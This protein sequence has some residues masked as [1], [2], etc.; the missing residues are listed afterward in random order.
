MRIEIQDFNEARVM[1]MVTVKWQVHE[2][3]FG[4]ELLVWAVVQK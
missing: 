1:P 4:L 2:S 3:W